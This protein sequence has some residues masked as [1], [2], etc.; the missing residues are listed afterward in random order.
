MV[1][2]YHL[3]RI[4]GVSV[5]LQRKQVLLPVLLVPYKYVIS[6]R[7]MGLLYPDHVGHTA[8]QDI[9]SG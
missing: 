8:R 9:A 5:L 7:K 2:E 1:V 4:Q 3:E 6:L